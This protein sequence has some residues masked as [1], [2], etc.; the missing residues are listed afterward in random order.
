MPSSGQRLKLLYTCYAKN[1]NPTY[2]P[3]FL[4][5]HCTFS[6]V[7]DWQKIVNDIKL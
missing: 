6:V 3:D 4:L 2:K 7:E 1:L 5:L